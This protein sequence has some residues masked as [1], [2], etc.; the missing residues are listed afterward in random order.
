MGKRCSDPRSAAGDQHGLQQRRRVSFIRLRHGEDRIHTRQGHPECARDTP[1]E[2]STNA[3]DGLQTSE[4]V[5]LIPIKSDTH[6]HRYD[7][8]AL[9]RVSH[10]FIPEPRE[11]TAPE[12]RLPAQVPRD[13]GYA[14]CRFP[15]GRRS[16]GGLPV[17]S[18][19]TS[20]SPPSGIRHQA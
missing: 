12:H 2:A 1:T 8:Y 6:G 9:G 3:A 7:T 17:R 5:V 16:L 14:K 20:S 11:L 4:R 13:H 15:S 19:S 10:N 18:S